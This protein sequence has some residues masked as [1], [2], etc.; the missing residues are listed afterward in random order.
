MLYILVAITGSEF[1]HFQGSLAQQLTGMGATCIRSNQWNNPS[2][3]GL[4]FFVLW[5]GRSSPTSHR[6]STAGTS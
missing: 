3:I 6:V 4:V 1:G 2:M 5:A